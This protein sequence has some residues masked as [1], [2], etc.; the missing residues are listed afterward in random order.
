V[1]HARVPVAFHLDCWDAVHDEAQ[2][3][4]ARRFAEQG[5]SALLSPYSRVAPTTWLTDPLAE[6]PADGG[7]FGTEHE[8]AG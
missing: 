7:A 8:L 5:L 4:Y 6:S 1:A 3:G 2:H